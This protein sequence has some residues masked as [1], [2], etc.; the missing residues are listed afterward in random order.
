MFGAEHVLI[1]PFATRYRGT[2]LAHPT[3]VYPSRLVGV[4]VDELGACAGRIIDEMPALRAGLVRALG[5]GTGV[6]REPNTKWSNRRG[7]VVELS[8]ELEADWEVQHALVLTEPTYSRHGYQQ[9]VV[10]L[11]DESFE[12]SRLDVVTR[13]TAWVNDSGRD[14][15][16]V[17]LAVP[18]IATA[19][20]PVYI[21]RYLDIVVPEEIMADVERA[22]VAHFGLEGYV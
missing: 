7:R 12:V 22:L 16:T 17:I 8:P 2:G 11:L 21:T 14:R 20:Q 10:P 9:T 5:F 13:D 1:D 4:G 19:Y 15:D 18:M 3:Y 6:T